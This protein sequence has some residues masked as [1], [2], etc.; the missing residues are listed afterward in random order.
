[1]LYIHCWLLLHYVPCSS[2]QLSSEEQHQ[3]AAQHTVHSPN[4]R[5]A[6]CQLGGLRLVDCVAEN[7]V[8]GPDV[9]GWEPGF[10]PLHL[11]ELQV[12]S[13]NLMLNSSLCP[14]GQCSGAGPFLTGSGQFFS[15]A[16]APAHIKK[17]GRLSTINIFLKQRHFFL[18]IEKFHFRI[19][20]ICFINVGTNEEN[21]IENLVCFIYGGAE[22]G[23]LQ[24][25]RPAPAPQHCF[26]PVLR[27]R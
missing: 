25:L 3:H 18:T 23:P 14:S 12:I 15:P 1:M 16:P 8:E 11:L 17:Y 4:L 9:G 26:W 27:S 13:H 21:M 7:V 5:A 22:A 20:S 10:P 2:Q 24:R 19:I 6:A